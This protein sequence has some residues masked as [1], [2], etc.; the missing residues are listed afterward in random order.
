MIEDLLENSTEEL[1]ELSHE[2]ALNAQIIYE[3]KTLMLKES[4]KAL[5]KEIKMILSG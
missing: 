5:R 2:D 3:K 1:P 4:L